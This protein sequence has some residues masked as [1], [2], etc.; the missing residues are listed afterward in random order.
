[1]KCV[2]VNTASMVLLTPL[3][4]IR[5]LLFIPLPPAKFIMWKWL[6]AVISRFS[7]DLRLLCDVLECRACLLAVHVLVSNVVSVHGKILLFWDLHIA[8]WGTTTWWFLWVT[9]FWTPSLLPS[10]RRWHCLTMSTRR[11]CFQSKEEWDSSS[12][13]AVLNWI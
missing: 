11:Y 3:P 4:Q 7:W 2:S 12:T 10:V 5:S 6:F 8:Q 13:G 9:P 1:M